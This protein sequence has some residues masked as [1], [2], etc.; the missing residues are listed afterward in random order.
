MTLRTSSP[1]VE[2][3]NGRAEPDAVELP[4][5]DKSMLKAMQSLPLVI[6]EEVKEHF[7]SLDHTNGND[8]IVKWFIRMRLMNTTI[9]QAL[10]RNS[11]ILA[12]VGSADVA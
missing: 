3:R 2:E 4:S 9:S 10:F 1:R 7:G 8:D 6:P 12:E 5:V 11:R